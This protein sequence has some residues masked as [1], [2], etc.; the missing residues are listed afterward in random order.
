LGLVAWA[1]YEIGNAFGWWDEKWKKVEDGQ[2]T[3]IQRVIGFFA[4]LVE[5]FTR[6]SVMI[7]NIFEL[8]YRGVKAVF[9][10]IADI[11]VLSLEN[12][13]D[14][15]GWLVDQIGSGFEWMSNNWKT[16][17][18]LMWEVAK[19]IGKDIGE[20]FSNAFSSLWGGNEN[21]DDLFTR[22]KM[23]MNELSNLVKDKRSVLEMPDFK[24][25]LLEAAN[26]FRDAVIKARDDFW[27]GK[28]MWGDL[29]GRWGV[30]IANVFRAAVE[31]GAVVKPWKG[32]G[33]TPSDFFTKGETPMD[34]GMRQY[35]GA[36]T[37]GSVEAFTTTNQRFDETWQKDVLAY[38]KTTAENTGTMSSAIANE[39][40]VDGL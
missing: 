16:V 28:N 12:V 36:A 20:V 18:K 31:K 19:Q 26:G 8:I 22:Q 32:M 2:R 6:G 21:W 15:F 7:L 34:V 10:F 11:V 25:P 38:L 14:A 33:G 13:S 17:L 24:N 5:K 4:D 40:T 9:Q 23:R 35:A 27:N 1:V 39:Q 30:A 37:R 29:F 3:G